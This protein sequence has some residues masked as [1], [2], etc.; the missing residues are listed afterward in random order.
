MEWIT[1]TVALRFCPKK[2]HTGKAFAQNAVLHSTVVA[3][4]V[5]HLLAAEWLPASPQCCSCPRPRRSCHLWG[6]C[7]APKAQC[8]PGIH[9]QRTNG[10]VSEWT[11][12]LVVRTRVMTGWVRSRIGPSTDRPIPQPVPDTFGVHGT[13]DGFLPLMASLPMFS[14]WKPSTS[15]SIEMALRTRSSST[16][17]G[18]GSWTRIP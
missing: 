1:V 6:C 10:H 9:K 5:C 11:D 16:W 18:R 3:L 12:G 4:V 14:G 7:T 17:A 15:F 2:E 8:Y 13:K